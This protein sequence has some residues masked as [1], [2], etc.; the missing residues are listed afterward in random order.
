MAH[1]I[2]TRLAQP[3]VTI[4]VDPHKASQTAAAVDEHHHVLARLRVPATRAGYRQSRRW[5]AC[6]PHRRWAVE[7]AAGLG[8]PLAQWLLGD[9]EQVVDVPAKL[10]ARVRLLS[11]GHGRKT[12]QADALST[13]LAACGPTALRA[14]AMEE[15]TTTLR[16]LS[17]RRDDLVARR[18]QVLNRLHA[19]LAELAPGQVPPHRSAAR[20]ASLLRHVRTSVGPARTRRLLAMDLVREVRGLDAAIVRIDQQLAAAVKDARS[21]LAG[22]FG[23][24]PLLAAKIPRADRGCTAVPHRR[25]LRLLLR[26]RTHRSSQRDVVRHRR[27]RAG[28]RQLTFALHVMAVTP[29]RQHPAGRAY[30]LRKRAE[31]HS[32]TEALRC[33][34]R[35]LADVI[36]RQLLRDISVEGNGSRANHSPSPGLG[37]EASP[38]GPQR[39]ARCARSGGA[40]RS[41]A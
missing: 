28:D 34:K 5:A 36:Y 37:G 24:G 13:A 10:S 38:N 31:G 30:Y 40:A 20:A 12:D 8:R 25:P 21:G 27:S 23:I 39:S 15:Q 6:W 2:P 33:L 4:G 11:T 22:L 9:G 7:N 16:L 14:A 32:D 19:V 1:R 18:T 35:R 41:A 17:D 29:T 26:G 3:A